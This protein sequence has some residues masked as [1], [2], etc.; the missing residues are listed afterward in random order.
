MYASGNDEEHSAGNE[1][2][3]ITVITFVYMQIQVVL[4][5][6]HEIIESQNHAQFLLW[7]IGFLKAFHL[8]SPP[9]NASHNL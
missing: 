2:I 1:H 3:M 8:F 6:I 5:L 7:L 9:I 4:G